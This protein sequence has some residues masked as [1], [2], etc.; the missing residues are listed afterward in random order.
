MASD[1]RLLVVLGGIGHDGSPPTV[2]LRPLRRPRP[3][4]MEHR[5]GGFAIEMMLH[6]VDPCRKNSLLRRNRIAND[7]RYIFKW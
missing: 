6:L 5:Y 4:G 2:A 3:V 1:N 7:V